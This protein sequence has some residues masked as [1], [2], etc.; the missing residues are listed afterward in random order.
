MLNYDC[1]CCTF[2]VESSFISTQFCVLNLDGWFVLYKNLLFFDIWILY[3]YI[4]LRS[5]TICCDFYR[6]IYLSSGIC[7]LHS[8]FLFCFQ[9]FLNYFV[10]K[11]HPFVILPANKQL[12]FWS[13]THTSIYENSELKVFKDMTFFGKTFNNWPNEL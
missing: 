1:C 9:L 11:F 6:G 7:L 4:N 3:Y 5:L 12:L 13:V 10:I 8:V 2:Y